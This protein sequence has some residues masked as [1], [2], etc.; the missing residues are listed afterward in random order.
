MFRVMWR[1]LIIFAHN[2]LIY[3]IIILIFGIWPGTQ[4][5]LAIPGIL[6]LCLN[7]IWASFLAGL[8][9]ARFRDIPMI[10][11]SEG[12]F[13]GAVEDVISRV[14][15]EQRAGDARFLRQDPY[16]RAMTQPPRIFL[17]VSPKFWAYLSSTKASATKRLTVHIEVPFSTSF[18]NIFRIVLSSSGQTQ[19]GSWEL[20]SAKPA[21]AGKA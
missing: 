12:R 4:A 14:V 10:A 16:G 20:Q 6:I 19:R 9:S 17:L 2:M 13:L 21:T 8:L 11:A 1:N 15:N 18:L 5:L 3:I 7:G